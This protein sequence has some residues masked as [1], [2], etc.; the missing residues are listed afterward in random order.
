M[1][2]PVSRYSKPDGLREDGLTTVAVKM[3]AQVRVHRCRRQCKAG[4]NDL[5]RRTRPFT[6]LPNITSANFEDQD[7][8]QHGVA[9]QC[10]LQGRAPAART[11]AVSEETRA[12]R[13]RD[14]SAAAATPRTTRPR[15]V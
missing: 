9:A 12:L 1:A 6:P 4:P 8:E 14:N 3:A 7:G 11:I 15:A 5:D 2:L 10:Q 13:N